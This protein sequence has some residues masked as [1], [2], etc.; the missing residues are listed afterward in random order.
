MIRKKLTMENK[1]IS[2]KY[3]LLLCM[4]T[5]SF[6]VN[7]HANTVAEE[8]SVEHVWRQINGKWE[9][10]K[11]EK[12]SY[13]IDNKV[14][15]YRWGY[16]ELINHNTIITL[17]PLE[18]YSSINYNIIFSSP[19]KNDIRYMSTFSIKED[20]VFYAFRFTGDEKSINKIEF[21]QSIVKDPEK[22]KS[23]KWNFDILS[24]KSIDYTLNFNTEYNVE[25][26]I[27]RKRT[28][29]LLNRKPVMTVEIPASEV[30]SGQFGFS[31][32]H[33]KPMI[34]DI[35][36]FDGRKKVF[37]EDFSTDRVRR[38]RVTGTIEKKK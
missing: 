21:I 19:L 9:I 33:F 7:L 2:F 8:L 10:K 3:Y 27:A 4:I 20:R 15:S 22:K 16:N 29:L 17:E 25:I 12:N 31:S 24:L 18:T 6:C 32:L 35:N 23:V 28:T 13:I 30:N 26:K 1:F 11:G 34:W 5:F 38:V 37:S 36:V 14:K